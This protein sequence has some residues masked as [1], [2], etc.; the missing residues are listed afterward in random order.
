M[1]AKK[2]LKKTVKKLTL[3]CSLRN[4]KEFCLT[5]EVLDDKL[6]I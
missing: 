4:G 3:S 2:R 1:I 6:K 5:K